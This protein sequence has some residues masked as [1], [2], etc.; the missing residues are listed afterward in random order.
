[1]LVGDRYIVTKKDRYEK[2]TIGDVLEIIRVDDDGNYV[3]FKNVTKNNFRDID[4]SWYFSTYTSS[5][6]E[7]RKRKLKKYLTE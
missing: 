3:Y 4:F 2:N 6:Y 1:M 7:E 5:H